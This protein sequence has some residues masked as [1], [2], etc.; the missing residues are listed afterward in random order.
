MCIFLLALPIIVFT[1]N[2]V[3]VLFHQYW[4]ASL[5]SR[6]VLPFWYQLTKLF[7]ISVCICRCFCTLFSPFSVENISICLCITDTVNR[8]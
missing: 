6:M 2:D 4:L 8:R 3:L 1:D 7:S 5:K